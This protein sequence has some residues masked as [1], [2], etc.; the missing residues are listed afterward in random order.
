M[1]VRLGA[2]ALFVEEAAGAKSVETEFN[3]GGVRGIARDQVGK[4]KA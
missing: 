4:C 2:L 3:R 1:K